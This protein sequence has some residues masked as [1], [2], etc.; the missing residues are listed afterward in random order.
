MAIAAQGLRARG[1]GEE[2]LLAPLQEIAAGGPTQAQ[3]WLALYH[4]AWQGDVTRI[5]EAAAV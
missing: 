2:A 5:F 4:G 3:A 1:L